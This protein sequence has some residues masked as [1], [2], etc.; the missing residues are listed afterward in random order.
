M[1]KCLYVGCMIEETSDNIFHKVVGSAG[2]DGN[3]L[4]ICS[5]H[6][7]RLKSSRITSKV[8][9]KQGLSSQ[10]TSSRKENELQLLPKDEEGNGGKMEKIAQKIFAKKTII[11]KRK[12]QERTSLPSILRRKK[13]SNVSDTAQ[14]T[15]GIVSTSTSSQALLF[16]KVAKNASVEEVIVVEDD[17]EP[18]TNLRQRRRTKDKP[19]TTNDLPSVERQDK[20]LERTVQRKIVV[21]E[22]N[23]G[24]NVSRVQSESKTVAEKESTGENLHVLMDK[25]VFECNLDELVESELSSIG[26]V[27]QQTPRQPAEN[28]VRRITRQQASKILKLNKHRIVPRIDGSTT[29]YRLVKI[30]TSNQG[31]S[32]KLIIKPEKLC[33]RRKGANPTFIKKYHSAVE[34]EDVINL[35]EKDIESNPV[36]EQKLEIFNASLKANCYQ[37]TSTLDNYGAKK[38]I[39]VKICESNAQNN[40]KHNPEKSETDTDTNLEETQVNNVNVGGDEL[41]KRR[42]EEHQPEVGIECREE[43]DAEESSTKKQNVGGQELRNFDVDEDELLLR[44]EANKPNQLSYDHFYEEFANRNTGDQSRVIFGEFINRST[45]QGEVGRWKLEVG[46][47]GIRRTGSNVR[48]CSATGCTSKSTE[49]KFF[50]FPCHARQKSRCEIWRKYTGRDILTGY[51]CQRHFRAEDFRTPCRVTLNRGVNPSY[52]T[53]PLNPFT[54]DYCPIE[55][56]GGHPDVPYCSAENC[57]LSQ[58]THPDVIYAAFPSKSDSRYQEWL[59]VAGNVRNP[60]F[61]CGRHFDSTQFSDNARTYLKTRAVPQYKPGPL[62]PRTYDYAPVQQHDFDNSPAN[63]PAS[64]IEVDPLTNDRVIDRNPPASDAAVEQRIEIPA[65]SPLVGQ[66]TTPSGNRIAQNIKVA[67][68]R[69]PPAGR[70]IKVDTPVGP[71]DGQK[72]KVTI[73]GGPLT[74]QNMNILAGLICQ[75]LKLP[76]LSPI[77]MAPANSFSPKITAV[78]SMA[79]QSIKLLPVKPETDSCKKDDSSKDDEQDAM[80]ALYMRCDAL[81]C[82]SSYKNDPSVK[83]FSFPAKGNNSSYNEK[84]RRQHWIDIV[85]GTKNNK[86][87]HLCQYHFAS[88]VFYDKKR[89]SLVR[90]SNPSFPYGPLN[91]ITNDYCP[92]GEEQRSLNS[93]NFSKARCCVDGC[94]TYS[95]N[96][97]GLFGFPMHDREAYEEW[98]RRVGVYKYFNEKTIRMKFRICPKHFSSCC[99]ILDKEKNS[100]RLKFGALPTINVPCFK[101]PFTERN[102]FVQNRVLSTDEI[103]ALKMLSES[104]RICDLD[105][106]CDKENNEQTSME[107]K[108]KISECDSKVVPNKK[109]KDDSSSAESSKQLILLPIQDESGQQTYVY[110]DFSTNENFSSIFGQSQSVEDKADGSSPATGIKNPAQKS[111]SV[112][113]EDEVNKLLKT[114]IC[115]YWSPEKLEKDAVNR[116]K[117]KSIVLSHWKPEEI[118]DHASKK[119]KEEEREKA[120]AQL[121]RI[122]AGSRRPAARPPAVPPAR[123]PAQ[124]SGVIVVRPPFKEKTAKQMYEDFSLGIQ[125]DNVGN[126]VDINIEDPLETPSSSVNPPVLPTEKTDNTETALLK[127]FGSCEASDDN[128]FACFADPTKVPDHEEDANV[129]SY[130]SANSLNVIRSAAELCEFNDLKIKQLERLIGV[131]EDTSTELEQ[132]LVKHLSSVMCITGVDFL[133]KCFDQVLKEAMAKKKEKDKIRKGCKTEPPLPLNER[134]P[135]NYR[136]LAVALQTSS[137]KAYHAMTQLIDL[138]LQSVTRDWTTHTN[139]NPGFS[140]RAFKLLHEEWVSKKKALTVSLGMEEV[141]LKQDVTWDGDRA[142]GFTDLG[143]GALDYDYVPE[144]TRAVVFFAIA[145]NRTWKLPLGYC[146]VDNLTPSVRANLVIQYLYKLSDTGIKCIALVCNS[147]LVSYQMLVE[148]GAISEDY[149]SPLSG[150]FPHPWAKGDRVHCFVDVHQLIKS[151]NTLWAEKKSFEFKNKDAVEWSHVERMND[152][153]QSDKQVPNPGLDAIYNDLL[154]LKALIKR[155]PR[156]THKYNALVLSLL[157]NLRLEGFENVTGTTAFLNQLNSVIDLFSSCHPNNQGEKQPITKGNLVQVT[158]KLN[159]IVA[160]LNNLTYGDGTKVLTSQRKLPFVLLFSNITSLKTMIKKVFTVDKYKL[161]SIRTESLSLDCIHQTLLEITHGKGLLTPL[162]FKN[163]FF[164]FIE[165]FSLEPSSRIRTLTTEEPF[166]NSIDNNLGFSNAFS[167]QFTPVSTVCES[168]HEFFTENVIE[169]WLEAAHCT[170]CSQLIQ[171]DLLKYGNHDSKGN[172]IEDI[173]RMLRMAETILAELDEIPMDAFTSWFDR[174]ANK[175]LNSL[176]SLKGFKNSS[177]LFN[178]K[179][180]GEVTHFTVLVKDMLRIFLRLRL[181]FLARQEKVKIK[182]PRQYSLRFCLGRSWA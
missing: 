182:P 66:V 89:T 36:D 85:G 178:S 1:K 48:T 19:P 113:V 148:L 91:P 52:P 88:D 145:L 140:E 72:I 108:R 141:P 3:P 51:L 18:K 17:E 5:T 37:I 23:Q 101:G 116:K 79:G 42:L 21:G 33:P 172:I 78:T 25:S 57:G 176:T 159:S 55:D 161:T 106:I 143:Y 80:H 112:D 165:T 32:D 77:E 123:P 35:V 167:Y 162:E 119:K 94:S 13:G 27:D 124:P 109:P 146:L 150:S 87:N 29:I 40:K 96:S 102:C 46:Q 114:R 160:Y 158:Q 163:A 103:E 75:N 56:P 53:G 62:N 181:C 65:V 49:V 132:I 179:P 6:F 169:N 4:Y 122:R 137:G 135:E 86:S 93:R 130:C 104:D 11:E 118:L 128:V 147:S 175:T 81:G 129:H 10:V 177:H 22:V 16:D 82:P 76:T 168:I 138:P 67:I 41:E 31:G 30:Y 61:L 84:K 127:I 153:I 45:L 15:A 8:S 63:S 64:V 68:P 174:L 73:P 14:K 156:S 126:E 38:H 166:P 136:K 74:G 133:K 2:R 71:V 117:T 92:V 180:F 44:I 125:E 170:D 39:N 59:S 98:T 100:V 152:F 24:Q 115:T 164:Q 50:M 7:A 54:N 120:L 9:C 97:S 151:V 131:G 111:K 155:D 95:N 139:G 99:M 47:D 69:V 157:K 173:H 83:Y 90:K 134:Y 142:F 70:I 171:K 20:A 144:A 110:A 60:R 154:S 28:N 12:N 121:A 26:P 105:D 149:Y 34:K 43:L 58:K 107:L